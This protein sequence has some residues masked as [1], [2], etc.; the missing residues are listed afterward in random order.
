MA[1]A[2]L[3]A[4]LLLL[5]AFIHLEFFALYRIIADREVSVNGFKKRISYYLRRIWKTFSGYQILL[6]VVYVLLTIPVLNLGLSS[7]ITEKLY[8][9]EFIVGELS[10]TAMMKYLLYVVF[11]CL[12]YL[13]LRLIY[14]LPLLAIK[15]RTV[16]EAFKESW[17]KTKKHQLTLVIKLLAISGITFLFLLTASFIILA[18]ACFFNPCLLYTSPSPRD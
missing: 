11:A 2:L 7:V 13:N 14:F 10:K 1:L 17:Q 16:K 6:F 8:V 9:P 18:L 3:F 15:H 12:F 4:Y 5:A